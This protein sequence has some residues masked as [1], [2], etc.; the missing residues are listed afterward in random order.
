MHR[1]WKEKWWYYFLVVFV[2][3]VDDEEVAVL[4][5]FGD[6]DDEVEDQE[7]GEGRRVTPGLWTV[8]TRRERSEDSLATMS[9]T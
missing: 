2:F 6:V 8:C 1:I 3:E 9:R 5:F 4:V 7:E